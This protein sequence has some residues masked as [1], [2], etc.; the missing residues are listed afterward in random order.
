M[1]DTNTAAALSAG[2]W[3]PNALPIDLAPRDG[4]F[5]RLRVRYEPHSGKSWT[6]LDDA[7]ESWTIGF[8]NLD[9]TGEDRWQVV[10][11]D[12]SQDF[13][14]EAVDAEVIGWLPFHGEAR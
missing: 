4:T 8:N 7:E 9:N 11:W 5:L 12:W 13:L 2:A 6:P 3:E 14:L 10:G 1:T